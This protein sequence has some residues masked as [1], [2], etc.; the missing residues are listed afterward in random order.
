MS[1]TPR[2]ARSAEFASASLSGPG[3]LAAGAMSFTTPVPLPA[4]A[5]RPV[6]AA[7]QHLQD[8]SAAHRAVRELAASHCAGAQDGCNPAAGTFPGSRADSHGPVPHATFGPRSGNGGHVI[9][10]AAQPCQA[11]CDMDMSPRAGSAQSPQQNTPSTHPPNHD[12]HPE[13][14]AL[15]VL[16]EE[17]SPLIT[18]RE[19]I[20]DV[21][22]GH[23]HAWGKT[24]QRLRRPDKSPPRG[25]D[26]S[27]PDMQPLGRGLA[28]QPA[29]PDL[30][31]CTPERMRFW[32]I[33]CVAKAVL[34]IFTS[35]C[36][37]IPH[38]KFRILCTIYGWQDCQQC[39]VQ[40]CMCSN[41][42]S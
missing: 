23:L 25:V 24:L 10:S 4:H 22:T 27:E 13:Q 28:G 2:D 40:H 38:P 3:P 1:V 39:A 21:L 41:N 29:E 7:A 34:Q 20:A 17:V 5:A 11:A 30:A 33:M 14:E 16:P 26:A 36:Y 35:C 19:K 12:I 6:A 9:P 15:Q 8:R 37:L 18:P 31:R 32:T 42:G